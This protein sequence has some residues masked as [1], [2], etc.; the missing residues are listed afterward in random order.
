ME[1]WL[2]KDGKAARAKSYNYGE[3]KTYTGEYSYTPDAYNSEEDE[4]SNHYTSPTTKNIH[5]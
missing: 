1:D 3:T 2:T 4:N 5:N